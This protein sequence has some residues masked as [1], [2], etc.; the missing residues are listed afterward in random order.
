MC[1]ACLHKDETAECRISQSAPLS[2]S[3]AR[4]FILQDAPLLHRSELNGGV[5]GIT[6]PET[7]PSPLVGSD[8][9]TPTRK[10]VL[11]LVYVF[12][13]EAILVVF[14]GLS[15][16]KSPHPTGHGTNVGILPAVG[17]PFSRYTLKTWGSHHM[18][19]VANTGPW[20]D[21]P[22]LKSHRSPDLHKFLP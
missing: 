5:E 2:L 19:S 8:L 7:F 18:V 14:T 4:L 3:N 6:T 11:N 1:A 13:A 12:L 17:D 20:G 10:V 22:E 9:G 16:H 15:H 21:E